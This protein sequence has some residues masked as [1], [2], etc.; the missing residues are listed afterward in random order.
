MAPARPAAGS[1]ALRRRPLLVLA[2]LALGLAAAWLA[3]DP[4]V[5]WVLEREGAALLGAPVAVGRARLRLARA[6]LSL[7]GLRIGN[8]PGFAAEPAASVQRL[9]LR[10][11][12]RSLRAAVVEVEELVV[13]G[14][15][16]RV[17][18]SARGTNWQALLRHA[19]ERLGAREGSA[20]L[21]LIVRRFSV[22]A[23]RASASAPLPGRPRLTVPLKDLELR[24]VGTATGGVT[25]RELV[26]ILARLLEPGLK[27][28]L[29]SSDLG[30]LLG[31]GAGDAAGKA[32]SAIDKLKEVFR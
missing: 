16:L 19:Q 22:R 15:A 24:D 28:A 25:P 4:L 11:A 5:A 6:E 14:A 29:H 31:D 9:T 17:E 8:P 7:E 27:N 26:G 21:R 18:G 3:L 23:A 32:G 12:P 10:I 20:P 13:Q 30:G 2:A 1:P